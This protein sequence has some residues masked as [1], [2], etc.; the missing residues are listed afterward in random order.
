MGLVSAPGACAQAGD[1][2]QSRAETSAKNP[3]SG[4]TRKKFKNALLGRRG[5][6]LADAPFARMEPREILRNRGENPEERRRSG[7]SCVA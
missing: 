5:R 6:D 2:A 4:M 3:T 7:Y 1:P